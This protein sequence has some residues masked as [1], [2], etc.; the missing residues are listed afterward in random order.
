MFF[1]LLQLIAMLVLP[2]L[3]IWFIALGVAGRRDA[4]RPCCG[5]CGAD[6]GFDHVD[7]D[8]PC[9]NCAARPSAVS[10]VPFRRRPWWLMLLGGIGLVGLSIGLT[11]LLIAVLTRRF[12]AVTLAPGLPPSA[13]L[14]GLAIRSSSDSDPA[15]YNLRS[16]LDDGELSV[17][18]LRALFL[19]HLGSPAAWTPQH[20]P[21]ALALAA[22]VIERESMMDVQDDESSAAFR[23]RVLDECFAPPELWSSALASS[24]SILQLSPIGLTYESAPLVRIAV[25]RSLKVDG[26][27]RDVHD[28]AR[29]ETAE[30]LILPVELKPLAAGTLE[31]E[32]TLELLMYT[33]FDALRLSGLDTRPLPEADW[34]V[35]LARTSITLRSTN[36]APIEPSLKSQQ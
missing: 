11:I 7:G 16:M 21:G 5:Q 26:I 9:G 29:D 2:A 33:R 31:F 32:V 19:A 20:S 1:G 30:S 6:I 14:V 24:P 27:A 25:V 12:S 28:I 13:T 15:L 22:L 23:A 35:P 8:A 3:G 4:T 18:N 34:P 10:P 17:G 36:V